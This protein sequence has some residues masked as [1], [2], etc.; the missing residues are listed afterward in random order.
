MCG[1]RGSRLDRP[2]EK[3]LVEVAG[4]PMIDRVLDGLGESRVETVHAVVSPQTPGTRAHLDGRLPIVDTPGEGYVADL[5]LALETVERPV[6]TCVADLPLVAGGVVD[7]L[8]AAADRS[9]RAEVP[10]QLVRSLGC[11]VEYDRDWLPTGLNVVA[12]DGERCDGDAWRTWDARLA[13]NVNRERDLAV[14][15][16]LVA[17]GP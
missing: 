9:T 3:P 2:R 13:V 15:E 16:E 4:R 6:V 1:G 17:D 8:V 7:D 5:R 10:A 12:D 11:R 14:A